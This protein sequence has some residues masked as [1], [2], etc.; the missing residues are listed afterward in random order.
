MSD[1]FIQLTLKS[2]SDDQV[3]KHILCGKIHFVWFMEGKAQ[4]HDFYVCSVPPDL[5]F[6][7]KVTKY[8]RE[9]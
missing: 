1:I 7:F 4:I 8:K 5:L 9:I 3:T 2:E 6:A